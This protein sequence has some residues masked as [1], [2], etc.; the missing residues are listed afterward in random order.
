MYSNMVDFQLI[1]QTNTVRTLK[2]RTMTEKF[3]AKFP[4]LA[5]TKRRANLILFI[6]ALV[7]FSCALIITVSTAADNERHLPPPGIL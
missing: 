4:R 2:P 5:P 1:E 7:L 6:I 3:M